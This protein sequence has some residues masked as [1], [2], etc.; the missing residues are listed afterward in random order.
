[1]DEK[2]TT[3]KILSRQEAGVGYLIFNNPQRHNAVSLEMWAATTE[4]LERF[5]DDDTVRV[6]VLTGAGG[7]AFVSG[8]DISKFES[9][10]SSLE[11]AKHY[12]VD[13]RTAAYTVSI[14]R[15]AEAVRLRGIY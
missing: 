5:R 11:A 4:V 7:K 3:D 15:V 1:M 13:M 12:N 8:A 6:V 14:K 10:R 9:E 2:T